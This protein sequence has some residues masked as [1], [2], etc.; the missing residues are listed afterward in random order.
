M[1][2]MCVLCVCVP[3]GVSSGG[4][5]RCVRGPGFYQLLL[6]WFTLFS[7][8]HFSLTLVSAS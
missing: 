7:R 2:C 8:Q 5:G 6:S 1:C 4:E 3:V